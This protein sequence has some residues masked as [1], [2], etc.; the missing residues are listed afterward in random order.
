MAI[1]MKVWLSV[2]IVSCALVALWALPPSVITRGV[3]LSSPEEARFEAASDEIR[4]A[5]GVLMATR[6]ADSLSALVVETAIDGLALAHPPSDLVTP[7]GRQEW[8]SLVSAHLASYQPRDAEMTVGIV[9]Q[10]DRH[11]ALTDVPLP[12]F[13]VR[14]QI[15]I[16][17]RGGTRYCFVVHPQRY[18]VSNATLRSARTPEEC[19]WFA[20]YGSPGPS[21]AAWL[22][23]GAFD[24]AREAQVEDIGVMLGEPSPELPFGL[25][26]PLDESV[27]AAAC[28]AGDADACARK[29]TDPEALTLRHVDPLLVA[30]S[31]MAHMA[32]IGFTPFRDLTSYWLSELEGRHGAEAFERFWKSEEPVPVAFAQAFETE[33]GVWVRDW[34][35]EELGSYRARPAPRSAALGWSVVVL[36]LCSGLVSWT[37]LRRRVA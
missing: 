25:S 15:Y 19:A 34:V 27:L 29:V 13:G 3:R 32:P 6:W 14:S 2:V 11:G 16:G 22:Q 33:L 24:F 5:H 31:P 17:V 30:E 28:M 7:T 23:N 18:P 12:R 37:Q 10:D 35:Q 4:R 36:L 20:K 26:K 8:R 21:I 9:F 1:G